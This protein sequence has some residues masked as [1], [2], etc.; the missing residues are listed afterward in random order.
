LLSLGALTV[1]SNHDRD[2][3]VLTH[4]EQLFKSV[5]TD[6]KK[7]SHWKFFKILTFP[8]QAKSGQDFSQVCQ[9]QL[10]F[11]RLIKIS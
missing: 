2:Q 8:I 9:D 1:E 11:L 3:G 7:I 5:E 4:P 10:R 6:F